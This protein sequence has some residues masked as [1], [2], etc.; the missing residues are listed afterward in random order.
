MN[1]DSLNFYY[2]LLANPEILDNMNLEELQELY[3]K[4]IEGEI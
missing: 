1:E 3:D 2:N 4:I